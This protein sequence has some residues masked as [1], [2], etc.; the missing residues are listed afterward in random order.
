MRMMLGLALVAIVVFGQ[1]MPLRADDRADAIAVLDEAIKAHGGA[2]ALAKAQ[3]YTRT[4]KGTAG[5]AKVTSE[6]SV[7]LPDRSRLAVD[8][9]IGGNKIHVVAV[10]NGDKG[11]ESSGGPAT[12][13]TA[14]RVRE[15]KEEG[16][17]LWATT[18]VPL[19]MDSVNLK[20]LPESKVDGKAVIVL[21]ASSK[22]KPDLRLYFDKES[23]LLLKI[24]RET[25]VGGARV[26]KEYVF[27]DYKD[28][29]GVKLPGKMTELI[30]GRKMT[31]ISS[32]QYKLQKPED[33]TF[34][35]P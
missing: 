3:N 30:N 27:G 8:L 18:L 29:D 24:E 2:D 28:V 1:T 13:M 14:T 17:V 6:Q 19:K 9:E 23:H 10:V 32:Q 15:M 34:G 5:E 4:G 16:Y 21:A 25:V 22:G 11:W 33:S 7:S 31:E 20:L 12:E 35:K 26:D